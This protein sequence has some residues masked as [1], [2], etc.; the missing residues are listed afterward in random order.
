MKKYLQ[1]WMNDK[2]IASLE[3]REEGHLVLSQFRYENRELDLGQVLHLTEIHAVQENVPKNVPL[4]LVLNSQ[5]V[6]RKLIPEAMPS[7]EGVAVMKAFPNLKL[8]DFYIDLCSFGSSYIVNIAKKSYVDQ[9][10][11]SIE[12]TGLLV[13]SLSLGF[14]AAG[15]LLAYTEEQE[16]V[17]PGSVL[18][19]EEGSVRALR[20]LEEHK[21]ASILVDRTPIDNSAFLGFAQALLFLQK[22]KGFG[23]LGTLN[24]QL[25]NKQFNRKLFSFGFQGAVFFFLAL[26]AFNFGLFQHYGNKN[27]EL[28]TQLQINKSATE[29][30]SSLEA[31]IK[32]KEEK[33]QSVQTQSGT[34]STL[35]L[36][37]IAS[38][39]PSSISLTGMTYQPLGQPI[40]PSKSIVLKQGV[41]AIQGSS[42]NQEQFTT[43]TEQVEQYDWVEQVVI[44]DY[45]FRSR[46]TSEFKINLILLHGKTE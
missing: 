12:K 46:T 43:W 40:N 18:V 20:P 19:L 34:Q 23:N 36:D 16:I 2:H 6:I 17:L 24:Q 1:N 4:V 42:K 13:G 14:G 15:A 29:Q 32:Q 25:E 8:D 7:E 38:D 45:S 35:L 26:L 11:L 28:Q 37:E 5:Q 27:A 30:L 41:L 21:Q 31:R 44:E 9:V 10:L 39:L 22:E 3:W 33:I